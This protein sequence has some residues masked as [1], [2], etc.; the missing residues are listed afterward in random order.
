MQWCSDDDDDDGGAMDGD[1]DDEGDDLDTTHTLT[2][3]DIIDILIRLLLEL[4]R[5]L[6]QN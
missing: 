1:D 4:K 5:R 3:E 2:T 6:S